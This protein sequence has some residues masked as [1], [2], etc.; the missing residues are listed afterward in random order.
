LLFDKARL[1]ALAAAVAATWTIARARGAKTSIIKQ[2]IERIPTTFGIS[3]LERGCQSISRDMIRVVVNRLRKEGVLFLQGDRMKGPMEIP[4]N[5][6]ANRGNE[7]TKKSKK[8]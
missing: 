1:L 8:S 2:A 5:R 6:F 3:D 4:G 7:G